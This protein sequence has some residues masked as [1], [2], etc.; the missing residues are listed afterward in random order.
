MNKKHI[1]SVLA[2]IQACLTQI[3]DKEQ[4]EAIASLLNMLEILVSENDDFKNENQSLKDEINR[5]KGE[6]GKPDIKAN[7]K[8]DGDVSSEKDRRE[9]EETEADKAKKEGFKLNK[10]SLEKLKEQRLPVKLL[11]QLEAINGNKYDNKAEFLNDIESI[12]GA[13]LTAQYR[14]LLIKYARYK[15]RKRQAKIPQIIID[16][17]VD[18]PVDTSQ[19]P[20]D[21]YLKGHEYKV[22][23][24]VVIKRD[25]VEFKRELY[26]SP[27]LKK[28][29]LGAVPNGYDQ[30]DFGPN[31]NADITSFKYVGGMSIPKIVEFYRNIGTLIS[32][33]YI[34]TRLTS[35]DV[36]EVFHREKDEMVQAAIEVSP[37]TQIDDTGTRVN[38]EN[39]YTQILCNDFFTAFFTTKHKNRLTVL[40]VLRNFESRQ[41]LLNKKNF[42]LLEQLGVSKTDRSLL[43]TYQ[44][45]KVYEETEILQLLQ[46]LY[47]DAYPQK[48]M[49]ILEACA[50]SCYRQE[51]GMAI[52]KVLV[53]DD[54]PQFKMLTD[55]LALCW[56][57]NERAYK[58]LNPIVELHQ[59]HVA[60]FLKKFWEYYR[61][62]ARYKTNPSD[63][64]AKTL[65]IEFDALFSTKTGY[66]ALDERIAKS[67]SQKEELLVVLNHPEVP[68]HNNC[69][70]GGARVEKR[71]RDV[72]LQTKTSEGTKSKDTMMS[73]VETCKK[74]GISAYEFIYDRVNKIYK[75]PSL[76]QMIKAKTVD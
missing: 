39:H 36:M 76:A 71:R 58:R 14:D 69:S 73:I 72:S 4:K 62:L 28:C 17:R 42:V 35:P 37:Y 64:Q 32:G 33:S 38:G 41:F 2:K 16:R 25:N 22:V 54:A 18:C 50:I 55:N 23:Q 44:S 5:L 24:D 74:L 68:L 10:S 63:G 53:S 49:R 66:E 19:L 7:K 21:A 47:G 40:D 6:Q 29:Y 15:K 20:D 26:Y 30:G 45:E 48:R 12:I 13:E 9:A 46:T 3:E 1:T 57:H 11:E 75:Y 65:G 31:I 52:V 27:S 43:A 67:K 56:V 60:D 70:E 61:K 59:Q 34:S 8:K 51:T